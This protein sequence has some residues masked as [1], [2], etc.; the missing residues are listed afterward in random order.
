[1][2][3]FNRARDVLVISIIASFVWL[4]VYLNVLDVALV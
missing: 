1:M 3:F 4:A 2:K